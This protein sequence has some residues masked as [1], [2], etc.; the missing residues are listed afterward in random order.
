MI[1]TTPYRHMKKFFW[2]SLLFPVA[3]LL[4][5][6]YHWLGAGVAGGTGDTNWSDPDNWRLDGDLSQIPTTAPTANDD[7][8]INLDTSAGSSAANVALSIPDGA[9]ARNVY[10]SGVRVGSTDNR[11]IQFEPGEITFQSFFF[12]TQNAGNTNSI[13]VFNNVAGDVTLHLTGAN[14]DGETLSGSRQTNGSDITNTR[15]PISALSQPDTVVGDNTAG[16]ALINLSGPVMSIDLGNNPALGR[17]VGINFSGE[18]VGMDPATVRGRI[19]AWDENFFISP[20]QNLS[21]LEMIFFAGSS[22]E[23]SP[24]QTWSIVSQNPDGTPAGALNNLADTHVLAGH[25]I[26]AVRGMRGGTATVPEMTVRSLGAVYDS[27]T[28][29]TSILELAGDVTVVGSNNLFVDEYAVYVHRLSN[30]NDTQLDLNGN[31]LTVTSGAPIFMDQGGQMLMQGSTVTTN[32]TF[33]VGTGED[34][35]GN[36]YVVGD[37][38]TEL[39]I[40]GNFLILASDSVSAFDLSLSTV[41]L[42]GSGTKLA[43]QWIEAPGF[44]YGPGEDA[45]EAAANFALGMADFGL[46]HLV[47]GDEFNQTYVRLRDEYVFG[48]SIEENL[49]NALYVQTLTVW[50]G[51]VLDL[52]IGETIDGFHVY[53]GGQ[54]LTKANLGDL[55]IGDG[56]VVIPEPSTIATLLGLAAL[57]IMVRRRFR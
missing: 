53:V 22:S 31:N 1:M 10:A 5:A 34:G 20:D 49:I 52:T 42:L 9:T 51:S 16:R 33:V 36:S 43:P 30:S 23:S 45:T 41:R 3:G 40:G 37:A 26:T 35:L 2:L 56:L 57:G 29:G 46:G 27:S 4:G 8:Y 12:S 18:G 14:P 25:P 7:V 28:D 15:I 21:D 44:D 47:I 13:V 50:E 32:G 39:N 38:D 19:G 54:L 48:Q 24:N 17:W 11:R 6:D 55:V